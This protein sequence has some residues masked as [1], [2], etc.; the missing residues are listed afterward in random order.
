M[1]DWRL[2]AATSLY[3]T[4]ASSPVESL[5]NPDTSLNSISVASLTAFF[6]DYFLTFGD[7]Q[8][9]CWENTLLSLQI[10]RVHRYSA[11]YPNSIWQ[12]LDTRGTAITGESAN[13][14][15]ELQL[16]KLISML[17]ALSFV[18]VAT[19][20]AILLVSLHA[21]LGSSKRG[22]IVLSALFA[23][24]FMTSLGFTVYF[25]NTLQAVPPSYPGS[26][27]EYYHPP[28]QL[29]GLQVC[30]YI[31]LAGEFCPHTNSSFQGI[32]IAGLVLG[33]RDYRHAQSR[34]MINLYKD[35]TLYFVS[36]LIA[37]Y[38]F[39]NGFGRI[40]TP[41][42]RAIHAILASRLVLNMR[43]N[44]CNYVET[45]VI[46]T[47]LRFGGKSE[48]DAST[49]VEE[50]ITLDTEITRPLGAGLA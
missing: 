13:R 15:G 8:A 21:L 41:W 24:G 30:Y 9:V 26:I 44:A 34:L 43:S 50:R 27:C 12:R 20:D 45:F 47:E 14:S 25:I 36:L 46:S 32:T 40:L 6:Y 49:S 29:D 11:E 19:A 42:Q 38:I 35:G 3:Y 5:G 10:H 31:L 37:P 2:V 22:G 48:S 33:L 4:T 28:K 18:G 7:E 1:E 17:K 23:L 39:P 16:D